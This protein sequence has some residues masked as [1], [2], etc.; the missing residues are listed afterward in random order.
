MKVPVHC[1]L[2]AATRHGRR[3]AVAC[4]TAVGLWLVPCAA[5]STFV[6]VNLEDTAT[7]DWTPFTGLDDGQFDFDS[8]PAT[9][10]D[11]A[12]DGGPGL[13]MFYSPLSFPGPDPAFSYVVGADI[14][15]QPGYH[16]WFHGFLD[17][18]PDVDG[19]AAAMLGAFRN[20]DN[21]IEIYW[22]TG[23]FE[24]GELEIGGPGSAIQPIYFEAGVDPGEPLDLAYFFDW[25]HLGG[26]DW[27]LTGTVSVNNTQVW[28]QTAALTTSAL[29]EAAETRHVLA[30]IGDEHDVG[31]TGD[32]HIRSGVFGITPEPG[33]ATL[34]L[35]GAG[36]LAGIR[37]R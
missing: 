17:G 18:S 1:P 23:F 12:V 30:S 2:S 10:T 28:S 25:R 33:R 37:R 29:V 13:A 24:N 36:L 7:A 16:A 9:I 4:L 32:T 19:S 27:Q 6:L 5:G 15:W 31:D 14:E 3:H 35:A 20:P 26:N 22:F 21:D 34:L 11:V 8:A